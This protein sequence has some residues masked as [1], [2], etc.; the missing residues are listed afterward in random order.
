MET[1]KIKEKKMKEKFS[2]EYLPRL[3]LILRLKLNGRNKIIPLNIWAVLITRYGAG[4]LKWNTDALKNLDW[5]TRK[6][7]KMPGALHPKSYVDRVHL[8]R[9]MGGRGLISWE[10]TIRMENDNWD[11]MSRIHLSHWLKV[12]KLHK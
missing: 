8:S 5:R 4:I 9:E 2:K 12:S 10:R 6:F 1:E 7:T 3:K 11:G